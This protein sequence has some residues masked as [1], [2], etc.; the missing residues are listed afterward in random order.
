MLE[1]PTFL[2]WISA[3]H[4]KEELQVGKNQDKHRVGQDGVKRVQ[5]PHGGWAEDDHDEE[6]AQPRLHRQSHPRP[7]K[8][9]GQPPEAD[10]GAQA[11]S[12][13]RWGG[14]HNRGF[15]I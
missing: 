5:L 2:L 1:G 6:G 12:G 10:A 13:G 15:Y 7:L 14:G 3:A 4:R 11:A 8:D 9:G